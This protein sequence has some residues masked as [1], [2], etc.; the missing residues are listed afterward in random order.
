SG[1]GTTSGDLTLEGPLV[2]QTGCTYHTVLLLDGPIS[3]GTTLTGGSIGFDVSCPVYVSPCRLGY[4]GT[5]R[6]EPGSDARGIAAS[7]HPHRTLLAGAG[8]VAL[9]A[10]VAGCSATVD[11]GNHL[12]AHT[13]G[14]E[15]AGSAKCRCGRGWCFN[16]L[17]MPSRD[18]GTCY[19]ERNGCT[20]VHGT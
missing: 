4:T 19:R 6:R 13:R 18:D 8:P 14:E 16:L 11:R 1:G 10:V 9:T 17:V 5:W 3:V 2:S 15:S 12:M 7:R 20:E